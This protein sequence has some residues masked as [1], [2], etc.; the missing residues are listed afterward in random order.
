MLTEF[1]DDVTKILEP[2]GVAGIEVLSK[3]CVVDC[4]N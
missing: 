2:L 1:E 4:E 3:V